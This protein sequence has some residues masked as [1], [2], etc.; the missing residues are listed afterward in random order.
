M[1]IKNFIEELNKNLPTVNQVIAKYKQ[2]N[3]GFNVDNVNN[4]LAKNTLRYNGGEFSMK[5]EDL[6]KNT[7][8]SSVGVGTLNF[9]SQLNH[10]DKGRG[11]FANYNDYYNFAVQDDNAVVVFSDES[12]SVDVLSPT[13]EDFLIFLIE[14]S[15]G[16]GN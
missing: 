10:D 1:T 6:I 16:Y 9:L 4:N 15:K 2:F 8:I 11:V 3:Q 7:N 12:D 14:Y 5:V 13:F